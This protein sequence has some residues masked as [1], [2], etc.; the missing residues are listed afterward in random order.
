MHDFDTSLRIAKEHLQDVAF[1][2][3][4]RAFA[5]GV[6]LLQRLKRWVHYGNSQKRSKRKLD[7]VGHF[8]SGLPKAED[9]VSLFTRE[10]TFLSLWFFE[11]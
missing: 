6:Q 3:Y 1:F 2:L 4:G 11:M 5:R 9:F 8:F 7:D 10:R